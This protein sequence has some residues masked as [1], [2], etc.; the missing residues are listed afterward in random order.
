MCRTICF[1]L[2][3]TVIYACS[4]S[5][6]V[7][8]SKEELKVQRGI[9]LLS[10]D[11]SDFFFPVFDTAFYKQNNYLDIKY[12]TGFLV[13]GLGYKTRANLIKKIKY[14]L[15]SMS[16][17]PYFGMLPIRIEFESK[18]L[19]NGRID[20]TFVEINNERKCFYF[21]TAYREIVEIT[22]LVN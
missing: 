1:S 2:F 19:Q 12:D 7:T 5:R 20:S 14:K 10:G 13:T 11:R 15:S 4:S 6:K 3:L 17:Y 8:K 21:N 16:N 18:M 9:L 22:S